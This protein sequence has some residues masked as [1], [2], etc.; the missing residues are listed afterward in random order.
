MVTTSSPIPTA[1]KLARWRKPIAAPGSPSNL[2]VQF[3]SLMA[4][5]KGAMDNRAKP[6]IRWNNAL[7]AQRSL[8]LEASSVGGDS[9]HDVP[10]ITSTMREHVKNIRTPASWK[11]CCL[12][13]A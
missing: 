6:T 13:A 9:K 8:A 4:L 7:V 10:M 2:P 3:L 12:T 5:V 1:A 11:V